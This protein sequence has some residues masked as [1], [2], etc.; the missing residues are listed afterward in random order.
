MSGT[1]EQE[2]WSV[3][4]YQVLNHDRQQRVLE[5]VRDLARAD[6]KALGTQRGRDWFV[7]VETSSWDGE[8]VARSAIAAID[9]HAARRYSFKSPRVL[10]P[11]PAS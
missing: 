3:E 6:V 9:A 4:I 2:R 11:L 7:V 8:Y 5:A 1:S 10:R